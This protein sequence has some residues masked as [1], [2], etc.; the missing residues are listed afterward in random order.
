MLNESNYRWDFKYIGRNVIC[1]KGL[2]G[3]LLAI[4]SKGWRERQI[5]QFRFLRSGHD[6]TGLR[7][8][9]AV[10]RKIVSRAVRLEIYSDKLRL[11]RRKSSCGVKVSVIGDHHTLY[12]GT[13]RRPKIISHRAT[14]IRGVLCARPRLFWCMTGIIF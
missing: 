14:L 11:K 4:D 13:V 12:N 6:G 8:C 10:I 9:G 1:G 3:F 2:P 5:A 7:Q